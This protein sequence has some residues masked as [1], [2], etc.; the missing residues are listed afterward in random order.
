MLKITI[1][2]GII[3]LKELRATAVIGGYMLSDL[4]PVNRRA[5]WT[6]TGAATR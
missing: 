1:S 2:I 3:P 6:P 5:I 4:S